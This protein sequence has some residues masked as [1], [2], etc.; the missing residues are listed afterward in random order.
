MFGRE[1]VLIAGAIRAVILVGTAFGLDWTA[2]Q[3][4]AVMLAVEAVLAAV[5][6]Q[7][8]TSPAT[9]RD[10]GTSKAEVTLKAERAREENQ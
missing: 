3:I 2:E 4:A 1:P 6:R 9:L 7:T 8:V 5:T 10:A